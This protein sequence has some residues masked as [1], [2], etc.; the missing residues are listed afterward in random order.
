MAAFRALLSQSPAH[1]EAVISDLDAEQARVLL[2]EAIE[3]VEELR[4]EL[5]SLREAEEQRP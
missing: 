2:G 4:A 5:D 1:R 3:M